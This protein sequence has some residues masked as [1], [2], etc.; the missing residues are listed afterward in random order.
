MYIALCSPYRVENGATSVEG[1]ALGGGRVRLVLAHL[2]LERDRDVLRDELADLLWPLGPPAAW[3]SS[4]REVLSRVRRILARL[5]LPGA[6]LTHERCVRLTLPPDVVVDVELAI[7][8]ARR[9]ESGGDEPVER[10]AELAAVVRRVASAPFLPAADGPWVAA[11]RAHLQRVHVTAIEHL[12]EARLRSGD[13]ERAVTDAARVVDVEPLRESGHH[14]LMR[15]YVLAGR[16]V[17]ALQAFDR[18]R[19]LMADQLGIDPPAAMQALHLQ[20][21]RDEPAARGEGTYPNVPS[22]PATGGAG[23]AVPAP[24][25]PAV[26][27]RRPTSAS[28]RGLPM[29]GRDRELAAVSAEPRPGVRVVLVEGETGAGKT[30]LLS[31]ARARA[32]TSGGRGVWLSGG[33]A[34]DDPHDLAPLTRAFRQHGISNGEPSGE[35]EAVDRLWDLAGGRPLTLVLDDVQWVDRATARFIVTLVAER[36][37]GPTTL[38]LAHRTDDPEPHLTELLSDLYRCCIPERLPLASLGRSDIEALVRQK[39][40]PLPS[41][42]VRSLTQ[43]LLMETAGTPFYLVEM[44][45]YLRRTGLTGA[46]GRRALTLPPSIMATVS[47]RLER[48]SPEARRWVCAAAVGGPRFR[49]TAVARA[50]GQDRNWAWLDALEEAVRHGLIEHDG[51]GAD[52]MRFRQNVVRRVILSTVSRARTADLV[53]RLAEDPELPPPARRQRRANGQPAAAS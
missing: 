29:T 6:L 27:G 53:V 8:A 34:A 14:L 1:T 13:A 20:V 11:R 26:L 16:R 52:V 25:R 19:E 9:I 21:L 39:V 40:G 28:S 31:E 12:A 33:C 24:A 22:S 7:D 5:D 44:L 43:R 18:C 15:A 32:G 47:H 46:E 38:V 3:P 51:R 30:R 45:D 49:P 37:Q 48:L 23:H 10:L 17:E 2:V 50:T 4:L 35:W 42:Q 36:A 41:T